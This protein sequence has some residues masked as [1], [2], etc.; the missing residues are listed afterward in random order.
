VT[1]LKGDVVR[2]RLPDGVAERT[3]PALLRRAADRAPARVAVV[4]E[5]SYGGTAELTYEALL[6][7][8]RRLGSWLS[9]QDVGR[10]DRVGILFDGQGAA[11]AHVA[12]HA[13]HEAGAI[14]VPLN[15]R[16]VGRELDYVVRASGLRALIFDARFEATVRQILPSVSGVVLVEAGT[17]S[18]LGQ[19][20]MHAVLS[21]ERAVPAGRSLDGLFDEDDDADWIY[22][23]GTTGHPKAVAL[24]HGAS[25]AC[26][27]EA[28]GLWGLDHESVYQSSAPFFTSTG[29][30]TNLLSC[31]AAACTHVVEPAFDVR[32]TLERVSTYGTTSLFLVSSMIAL[33]AQR[34]SADQLDRLDLSSLKRLCYGAQSMPRSFYQDVERIFGRWKKLELVHL[35]GLTEAG[36]SG[37]LVSPELHHA[38]LARI[39]PYGMPVG[40]RGFNEWVTWRVG[41]PDGEPVSVGNTGEILLRAP[42]LMSRYVDDAE[43][44]KA[45]FVN[46]WLRTGDL[47]VVD[48]EGFVFFVDRSSHSI[49]RGGLNVSS[50]E[51]ESVIADHP[52]VLQA[53]VV[54]RPDPVLGEEIEAYV[55]RVAGSVLGAEELVSYCCGQL[56]DY[57][58]PRRVAFMDELPTNA[59]NRVVKTR[60]ASSPVS[61]P[62]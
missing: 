54:G 39:G 23:S 34:F 28:I 33:I 26:G 40:T 17:G 11:E 38:A 35:Y 32:R 55:V 60:L 21:G 56:A 48:V 42:S 22:T 46:G 15:C 37:L 29:C 45:K 43:A 57:K 3:V 20:F 1:G 36:P 16:Y 18:G 19:D 27:Y 52:D 49:R 59:M 9:S 10:G 2:P 61:E 5:S 24:S 13:S 44:T 4:A 31:L 53:A 6:D 62:E 12:Y 14:A 25:V 7:S 8:A 30:H 51:V 41:G 47:G 58:V 50:V